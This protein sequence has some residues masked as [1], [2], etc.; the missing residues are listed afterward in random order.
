MPNALILEGKYDEAIAICKNKLRRL[1]HDSTLAHWYY[2][3][4]SSAYYEKRNYKVALKWAKLSVNDHPNCP[5]ALWH[6]AGSLYSLNQINEAIKVYKK[7]MDCGLKLATRRCGEGV[8]R[9]KELRS[10]CRYRLALCYFNKNDVKNAKKW[11][12]LFLRYYC[13]GGVSKR[14]D[15]LG[16][17]A[18]LN[19]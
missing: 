8:Q 1:P 14:F 15:G 12:D 6:Y 19:P 7:I 9:A 11:C 17:T 13:K 2:A 4:L 18:K 5:I 16:L 10:D 3:H